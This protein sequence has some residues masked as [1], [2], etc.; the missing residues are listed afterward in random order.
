MFMSEPH[1]QKEALYQKINALF[2]YRSFPWLLEQ[3]T[4]D[5]PAEGTAFSIQLT[6]LQASIYMLDAHLEA[7]WHTSDNILEHHWSSI[8]HHLGRFG[9]SLHKSAA[10]L[11]HIQKYQKHELSLRQRVLPQ[12]FNMSYFYFYKSCDVKLLRR[13][14]Y[15]RGDLRKSLGS[16][17]EWRYFDLVTEVNDD[18]EDLQ[19]DLQFINGNRFLITL[20]LDGK[21]AAQTQF[22]SFLDTIALRAKQFFRKGSHN[23]FRAMILSQTLEQVEHT[24]KQMLEQLSIPQQDIRRDALI[25]KFLDVGNNY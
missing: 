21:M 5:T 16:L 8:R 7:N 25:M 13:L 17:N 4:F 9:I 12:S 15:E 11:S 2:T 20:L 6:E 23:V 1:I 19:E 18:V 14:I 24:K 10:Y 22:G 3:C